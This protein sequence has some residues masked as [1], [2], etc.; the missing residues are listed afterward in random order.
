MSV[1]SIKVQ[2]YVEELG[3]SDIQEAIDNGVEVENVWNQY[4]QVAVS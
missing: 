3:Y 4:F 2:E 1:K